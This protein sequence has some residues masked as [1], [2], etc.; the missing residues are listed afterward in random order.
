MGKVKRRQ[1]LRYLGA[2]GAGAI[3]TALGFSLYNSDNQSGNKLPETPKEEHSQ[4][5]TIEGKIEKIEISSS[6]DTSKTYSYDGHIVAFIPIVKNP[7]GKA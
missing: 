7:A 4:N 3:L 6:F 1:F 5:L 2:T